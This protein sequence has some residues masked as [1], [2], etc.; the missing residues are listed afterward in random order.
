MVLAGSSATSSLL[1]APQRATTHAPPSASTSHPCVPSRR[2]ASRRASSLV[3]RAAAAAPA[4]EEV[5]AKKPQAPLWLRRLSLARQP[6][7]K[8]VEEGSVLSIDLGGAFPESAAPASPFSGP[9][10]LTLPALTDA[11]RK[12][13]VDPRITGVFFKVS[14]VAAG[15]AKLGAVRAAIAQFRETTGGAKFTMAFME[16][17]TEREF[18]LASSC[19]EVYMPPSAYVSLRGLAV[20]ATFLR[21][22]LETAGIEPQI[23]RIGVYKSAGD[24]LGRK[25]MSDA[26]REV[27]TSLLSQTFAEWTSKVAF[28]RGKTVEDVQA[29]VD[30]PAPAL[31]PQQLADAGWLTGVMYSDEVKQH[32]AA[33]TGG[34]QGELRSVTVARYA[35]T[36]PQSLGLD[37]GPA[38]IGVIRASG[39][40]SRGRSNPGL[41]RSSSGITN[42]DFI[43][44]LQRAKKDPRVKAILLRIDSP[45]GDALASDL[46]W[47][48]LR[49]CGKPVIASMS[50]VAAS[51]GY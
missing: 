17:A 48:E 14:P 16:L 22:V 21:G 45:G 18:Y 31:T 5:K 24:Q 44:T 2:S 28:S 8:F 37:I 39:A 9:Q 3:T 47:R 11:L 15:W 34:A 25:T 4:V 1:V 10:S 43:K 40:I 36:R 32:L 41:G 23:K 33:R 46:M 13:S 30:A 49:T 27:L 12:A 6:P 26:Q 20:S 35:R 51:G 19:E 38:T 29:L 42:E 7:W 50:D